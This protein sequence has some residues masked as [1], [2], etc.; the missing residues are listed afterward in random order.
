MNC[1]G[2]SGDPGDGELFNECGLFAPGVWNTKDGTP[3]G[4]GVFGARGG[5][6]PGSGASSSVDD[7]IHFSS[8]DPMPGCTVFSGSRRKLSAKWFWMNLEL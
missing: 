7:D 5:V 6:K 8:R 4:S 1:N 2:V 3:L